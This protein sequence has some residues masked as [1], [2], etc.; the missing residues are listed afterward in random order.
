V[1]TDVNGA[2]HVVQRLRTADEED[3]E[4]IWA[5]KL[6]FET[7]GPAV[8]GDASSSAVN[9]EIFYRPS[10]IFVAS[11]NKYA[12]S[13]GT[14]D[15]EDLWRGATVP[16]EG[17]F[18][19]FV[20]DSDVDGVT[21]PMTEA[22]LRQVLVDDDPSGANDFDSAAGARGW[23][24]VLD[25]DERVIS[26][27]F[28]LA[29]VSFFVTFKPLV[30]A[31]QGQCSRGG[32]SRIFAV[33]TA[34]ADP[35]LRDVEN[36]AAVRYIETPTFATSPFTEQAQT[37]NVLPDDADSTADDLSFGQHLQDVMDQLKALM[38][39]NCKFGNYRID[40]KTIT[41]DTGLVFIAPVPV[42]IIEKNWKE[43]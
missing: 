6:I 10:V 3:G 43:F 34:N 36:L 30:E 7:T 29:G 5:P 32:T 13:F 26:D 16:H 37:K 27:S 19:V 21:L 22:T 40:V 28:A 11:L 2:S 4:P 14:G 9:R 23:Y 12:L 33:N 42:C 25:Q 1:V 20:D 39:A 24:L 15:R 35:L 38:P 8:A 31:E 18:Y 17:R 41:S